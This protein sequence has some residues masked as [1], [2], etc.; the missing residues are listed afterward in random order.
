MIVRQPLCDAVGLIHADSV[1]ADDR[2]SDADDGTRTML[3]VPLKLN[4]PPYLPRVVQ[5]AAG[6]RAVVAV[7][8][9][10]GQRR[11]RPVVEGVRRHQAAGAAAARRGG[12]GDV[13][14]AAEVAGRVDRAAP[15]SCSSSTASGRCR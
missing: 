2:F 4:A 3:L 12:G 8:R 14:V 6:D 13:G 11:A 9:H 1:I 10:V 15:G 7:A 5:V